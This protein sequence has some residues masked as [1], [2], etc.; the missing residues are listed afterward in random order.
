[1]MRCF[2]DEMWV[3]SDDI[4]FMTGP[5]FGFVTIYGYSL[6]VTSSRSSSIGHLLKVSI[7]NSNDALK[8]NL[9]GDITMIGPTYYLNYKNT[10]QT[11]KQ[12]SEFWL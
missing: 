6:P 11:S 7:P 5:Y 12:T 4:W 1:M 8:L 10:H 2:D 9:N 3:L